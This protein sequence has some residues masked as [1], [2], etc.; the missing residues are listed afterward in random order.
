M[1]R[2]DYRDARD[3]QRLARKLHLEQRRRGGAPL[4]GGRSEARTGVSSESGLVETESIVPSAVTATTIV[5]DLGS[6]TSAGTPDDDYSFLIET[7]ISGRGYPVSIEFRDNYTWSNTADGQI[8]Y[9]LQVVDPDD[10][11]VA[12]FEQFVNVTNSFFWNTWSDPNA[13]VIAELSDGVVYRAQVHIFRSVNFTWDSLA[14]RFTI[15]DLK[16]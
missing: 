14:R 10:V 5:E 8:T 1:P 15:T 4:V 3:A 7:E 11:V 6:I 12:T 13:A 9:R 16:R 2:E